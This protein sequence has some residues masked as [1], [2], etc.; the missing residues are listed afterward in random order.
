[1]DVS[2]FT[3]D[4]RCLSMRIFAENSLSG[5]AFTS[6]RV[7]QSLFMYALVFLIF[8]L[9]SSAA[10]ADRLS[11]MIVDFTSSVS[12]NYTR[13]LPELIVDEIVNSGVFDVV[14][15]EK[16]KSIAN[17]FSLQAGVLVDPGKAV[18]IG[19]MSGAQLMITGNIVENWSSKKNSVAY[20]IKSSIS[21]SHLKAR[22]EVVDLRSGIKL[23]S[24]VADDTAVLKSTGPNSV[25]RGSTSLGPRVA[26]ELVEALLSSKRII[27]IVDEASGNEDEL[28][29]IR[30]SS[31]PEGADV[32]IDGVYM[33]NTGTAFEV[34]PG[35]HEVSVSLPGYLPWLK[36][37]KA[38]DGLEFTATLA[39]QVDQ[40]IEVQVD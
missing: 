36:Q 8:P 23:F 35:I 25:G 18:E 10:H 6:K 34:N 22:I 37:V 33:G 16:L 32:E 11:V 40:R 5:L 28:I 29:E 17:E 13:R 14:E 15:R 26:N 3:D 2:V 7:T 27:E 20:G 4:E 9:F 21:R 38:K 39:K 31:V 12:T 1:M 19:S 30:I 24:H